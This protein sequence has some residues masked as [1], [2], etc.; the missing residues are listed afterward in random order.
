MR[1]LLL[2]LLLLFPFASGVWA[3]SSAPPATQGETLPGKALPGQALPGQT[4]PGQ[5]EAEQLATRMLQLMESTAVAVPGL[6]RASEPLKQNAETTFTAMQRT[7]QNAALIYQFM[8]QIRAYLAL[9]DSIGRPDPFPA[10]ADQQYAELRE[11]LQHMQQHFEAILRQNNRVEQRHDTDPNNLKRYAEADSKL[12]PPTKL[13]RVVFLGDS[14][15]DGWRL[16]EYFTGR[17]FI[18][19]GIGGQTTLQMLARFRQDVVSLNPKVVVI[20]GGTNDIAAGVSASQ[21]E[22]NLTM[23]GDLA[24]AHGIR[25]V[26]ASILPVSDYHKDADP[27]SE[28]TT[29]HP[30]AAIQSI[31]SWIRSYC[32]SQGF[33]YMD[34]YSATVDSAGQLQVDLSDDGLNPNGKGYRVMSPVAIEAIGRALSGQTAGQDQPAKRRFRILSQ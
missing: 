5:N 22:D 17:D 33:V 6:I 29:N 34:Y 28:M 20:L 31:N 12:P 18:N 32:Q 13:P 3:Q 8:N 2:L 1:P 27:R 30:A 14:I 11:G 7:P 23:V 9:S 21:I 25:P 10:A 19:R 16:N 15:T 24:K 4:A 26:F